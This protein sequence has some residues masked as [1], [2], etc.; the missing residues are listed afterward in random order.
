M[1]ALV[2]RDRLANKYLE[3]A[4][5]LER[6]VLW[7]KHRSHDMGRGAGCPKGMQQLWEALLSFG[8][9]GVGGL[10]GRICRT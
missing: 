8:T 7:R 10:D 9:A 4:W 6:G 2:A 5:S 3:Q 1:A